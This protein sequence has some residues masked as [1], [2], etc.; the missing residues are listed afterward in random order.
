MGENEMFPMFRDNSQRISHLFRDIAFSDTILDQI[1]INTDFKLA[2]YDAMNADILGDGLKSYKVFL[3]NHFY[4]MMPL[5]KQIQPKLREIHDKTV[6]YISKLLNDEKT[7]G[8]YRQLV[9]ELPQVYQFFNDNIDYIELSNV[10][11]DLEEALGKEILL[12]LAEESGNSQIE[13]MIK[14][15]TKFIKKVMKDRAV[16]QQKEKAVKTVT[17]E[18]KEAGEKITQ[19]MKEKI[20]AQVIGEE[21]SKA[22]EET[23]NQKKTGQKG[24]PS[25]TRYQHIVAIMSLMPDDLK[26]TI[27]DMVQASCPELDLIRVDEMKEVIEEQPVNFIDQLIKELHDVCDMFGLIDPTKVTTVNIE[28][29]EVD[30]YAADWHQRQK[31]EW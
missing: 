15:H 24:A 14:R 12:K 31:V 10:D 20:W 26:D 18:N 4:T 21:Q 7:K 28:G 3:D 13:S 22:E 6:C 1:N 8:S 17:E 27:A 11:K 29:V 16:Q 30:F 2:V 9:G 25:M 23:G 5:V 19:E